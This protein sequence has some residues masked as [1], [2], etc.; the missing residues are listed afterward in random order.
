MFYGHW[1]LHFRVLVKHASKGEIEDVK[2]VLPKTL[3]GIVAVKKRTSCR[4]A[5]RISSREFVWQPINKKRD[6]LRSKTKA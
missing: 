2:H 4:F 3:Q 1:N 5:K 6:W